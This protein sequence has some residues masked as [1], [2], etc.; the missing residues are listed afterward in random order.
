M[1]D[2]IV[3]VYRGLSETQ[4]CLDSVL[5]ARN[6]SLFR[7]IVINDCSPEPELSEWL[8]EQA[9]KRPMVLLENDVNLGFVA[10]VNRG[11]SLS[12]TNDVVLL[13]SDT[14]VANN[15]LDRLCQ[16]AAAPSVGTVTPFSNNATICSY[17]GFCQ[18]NELPDGLSVAQLDAIFAEANPEPPSTSL[19]PSVSACISVARH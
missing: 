10:T 19:R 14:E 3:P 12:E 15:W 13:N 5:G 17:P 2:V 16:A 4:A 8:R 6:K 1:I 9:G 18:D 11:M 7:L